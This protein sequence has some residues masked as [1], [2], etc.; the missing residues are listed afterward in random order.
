MKKKLLA[1]LSGAA[2]IYAL[3]IVGA[4]E[5]GAPF[6]RVWWTIPLLSAAFFFA[7]AAKKHDKEAD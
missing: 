1:A 6:V 7:S 2:F 4:V 3:G 5:N